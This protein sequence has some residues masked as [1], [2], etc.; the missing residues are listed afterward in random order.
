V[1]AVGHE[2]CE[3]GVGNQQ[4]VVAGFFLLQCAEDLGKEEMLDLGKEDGFE[5]FYEAAH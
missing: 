4:R 1:A 3:E 5:V 2:L